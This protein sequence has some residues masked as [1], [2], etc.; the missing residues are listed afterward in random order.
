MVDDYDNMDEQNPQNR[1]SNGYFNF[2][3]LYKL[4]EQRDILPNFLDSDITVSYTHLTLPT[5]RIV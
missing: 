4:P 2:N 5:K 1:S 3:Y